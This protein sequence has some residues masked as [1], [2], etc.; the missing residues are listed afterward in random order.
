MEFNPYSDYSAE[1]PNG[2]NITFSDLENIKAMEKI[3]IEEV[4]DTCFVLV[5]GGLGERLGYNGIKIGIP[6]ELI[7]K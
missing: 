7:T 5:A 6:L 1:I 2:Y 4:K 3:G